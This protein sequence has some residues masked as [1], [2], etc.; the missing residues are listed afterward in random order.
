LLSIS[1]LT[2][3]PYTA[4]SIFDYICYATYYM[5]Q[6]VSPQFM[7]S[8]PQKDRDAFEFYYN[9]TAGENLPVTPEYT[10]DQFEHHGY[11]PFAETSGNTLQ[12]LDDLGE[13]LIPN[14][15]ERVDTYPAMLDA[16]KGRP[17]EGILH[18]TELGKAALI[19][20]AH[21]TLAS[22][23]LV[24]RA[25]IEASSPDI[26]ERLNIVFG[27]FPTV[28]KY[29]LGGKAVSPVAIARSE[30]NVLITAARTPSNDTTDE[31]LQKWQKLQRATFKTVMP[32]KT[33][34]KP[35]G[36]LGEIIV[37]CTTG[38][39]V[40]KGVVLRP[41]GDLSYLH[42]QTTWNVGIHD[43][44]LGPQLKSPVWMQVDPVPMNIREGHKGDL[45]I[46]TA[47]R[48]VCELSGMIGVTYTYE[49]RLT[50]TLRH[51]FHTRQHSGTNQL[52]LG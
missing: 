36:Q 37:L 30:G 32:Q 43:T 10:W 13:G 15:H 48:R 16:F 35:A 19:N 40:K 18:H 2:F 52:H 34:P 50:Q 7:Y 33:K 17:I 3:N 4:Y 51:G 25:I 9:Q 38:Q 42:G 49:S 22:P 46:H 23:L 27:I 45:D 31:S 47:N 41:D 14:Y 21:P 6:Q 26:R 28:F 44:L 11:A 20:C 5:A 1:T 8:I 29:D 12:D 39:R 24:A